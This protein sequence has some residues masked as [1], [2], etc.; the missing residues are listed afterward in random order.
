VGVKVGNVEHSGFPTA[1][2]SASL[3]RVSE[4]VQWDPRIELLIRD[5]RAKP[6]ST[7]LLFGFVYL[8]CVRQL[9]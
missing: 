6:H 1:R 7:E 8:V 5:S 9:Q 2:G 3:S 4:C